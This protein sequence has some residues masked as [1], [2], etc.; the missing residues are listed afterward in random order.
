MIDTNNYRVQKFNSSSQSLTKWG[1]YGAGNGQFNSP[2]GIAV[3]DL[4]N[5][6]VDDDHQTKIQKFD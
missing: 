5:V 6:Y 1:T 4:D 2:I 3:D